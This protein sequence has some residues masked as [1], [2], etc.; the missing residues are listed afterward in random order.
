M[1]G[2]DT[3]TVEILKPIEVAIDPEHQNSIALSKQGLTV[4]TTDSTEKIGS[5][6]GSGD[7]T[8][9]IWDVETV[10][11]PVYSRYASSLTF[12]IGAK[13]GFGPMK[14]RPIAMAVIWLQDLPDDEEVPVKI[15]IL[16]SKDLRKLR[17]NY[18]NEHTQKG[19]EY[20][21]VGWLTTTV[22]I[23]KGLDPVGV[24]AFYR[25][26][27]SDHVIGSREICSISGSSP[28]L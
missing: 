24:L 18:I 17:Q 25:R 1:L 4:T 26:H 28:C 11:L 3:G 16:V 20:K 7:D 6:V 10:R 21:T 22:R 14:G 9:V 27:F 19:H 2:W 8:R 15:P 13:G 12:E 5:P 23:D